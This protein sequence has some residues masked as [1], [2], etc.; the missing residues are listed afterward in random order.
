MPRPFKNR[1]IN[2]FF[3]SD[4]FKPNGIPMSML[5]GI[6]L[7]VDELEA[8][9]LA[10]L[11]NM[12]HNDAAEKMGVSR[13]TFGNIIKRARQK[14]AD[15]IVNAKALRIVSH[16]F[17][18]S[19]AMRQC[20]N[21]DLIWRDVRRGQLQCPICRSSDNNIPNAAFSEDNFFRRGARRRRFRGGSPFEPLVQ[22]SNNIENGDKRMILA[23]ASVGTDIDAVLDNRFGRCAYF[24]CY[25]TET[26]EL[27]SIP[28]TQ[29]LNAAQ[30]AGIQAATTV[31]DCG[32]DYVFCAHCGPK[33]FRV[34]QAADIKVIS[35]VGGKISDLIQDFKAGKLKEANSADVEGHWG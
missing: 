17:S 22:D 18:Y 4:C 27:A 20:R 28:N 13:Q 8:L 16:G 1:K 35:G 31:A 9:R 5:A 32:A 25:D 34:L 33:A 12:Y 23:F 24:V 14:A 21:C 26:R 15:A 7:S 30:G 2:G 29:N 10:D 11:E 3:N 19:D 6:E